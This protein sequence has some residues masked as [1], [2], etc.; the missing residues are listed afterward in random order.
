MSTGLEI[1]AA[2][3]KV[4][5]ARV[6]TE[7]INR[8]RDLSGIKVG[9]VVWCNAAVPKHQ[10]ITWLMV[11]QRLLTKDRLVRMGLS[12]EDNCCLYSRGVDSHSHLFFESDFSRNCWKQILDWIKEKMHHYQ[13]Q[14]IVQ[15][16]ARNCKGDRVRRQAFYT[17]VD[18]LVYS[19]WKARNDLI[20]SNRL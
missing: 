2:K 18:A 3:S 5:C 15:W 11:R 1:S 6:A 9:K 7:M 14:H 4:Y 13:L 20:W 16:L 8:I 12:T 19:I 17:A 10:F